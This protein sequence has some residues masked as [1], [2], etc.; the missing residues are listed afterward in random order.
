MDYRWWPIVGGASRHSWQQVS[1]KVTIKGC[2]IKRHP[3]E[4]VKFW[5]LGLSVT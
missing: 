3:E 5:V 4:D 2:R 1:T